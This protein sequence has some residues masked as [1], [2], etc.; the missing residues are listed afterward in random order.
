MSGFYDPLYWEVIV[1]GLFIGTMC[2]FIFIVSS[3]WLSELE[4]QK[5]RKEFYMRI[6]RE[7]SYISF[8]LGKRKK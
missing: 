2:F 8:L 1:D 4:A 7:L 3:L 5:R 6:R